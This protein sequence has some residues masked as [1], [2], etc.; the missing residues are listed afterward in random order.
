M[1]GSSMA[2]LYFVKTD[3]FKGWRTSGLKNRRLKRVGWDSG[4]GVLSGI[5]L[6]VWVGSF[7]EN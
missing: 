5:G 6:K 7:A 4:T 1:C 2:V 3:A